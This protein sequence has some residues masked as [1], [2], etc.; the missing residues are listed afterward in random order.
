MTSQNIK[1][2]DGKVLREASLISARWCE[3]FSQLL[4][5]KSPN[6]DLREWP[7][8]VQQWLTC[9]PLDDRPF[10]L[11]VEEAIRGWLTGRPSGLTTSRRK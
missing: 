6:L 5:T 9:V 8:K 10:P 11:E 7:T 2:K 4:S 1:A 3:H